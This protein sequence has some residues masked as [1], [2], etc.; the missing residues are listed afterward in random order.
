MFQ[1]N[2]ARKQTGVAILIVGKEDFKLKLVRRLK[3]DH[4]ILIK[5]TIHQENA[6]GLAGWPKW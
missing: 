4:F 5:G 1:A 3:E 6:T 2:G